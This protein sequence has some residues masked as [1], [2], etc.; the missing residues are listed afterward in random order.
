MQQISYL[1]SFVVI[2]V[3]PFFIGGCASLSTNTSYSQET[4]YVS[5]GGYNGSNGFTGGGEFKGIAKLPPGYMR[6][7]KF[8]MQWPVQNPRLNRGFKP[9]SDRKHFGIDLGGH[10]GEPILAAHE[11]FVIFAGTGFRGYGKMII[12][13]FNG[14]FA[15]LYAHLDRILVKNGQFV[16]PGQPIGQMGRTGRATGV[17]LHFELLEDKIPVDPLDWL[18]ALHLAD[19]N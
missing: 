1:S 15:T 10:R 9:P 6:A 2:V 5:P 19:G 7:E 8:S 12:L 11:G 4:E 3:I 13:E 16:E 17:H 14:N 18:P